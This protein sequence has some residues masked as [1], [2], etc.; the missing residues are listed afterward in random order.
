ME[1]MMKRKGLINW[2]LAA[3]LTAGCAML[4]AN[5]IVPSHA[6]QIAAS[7]EYD[8]VARPEGLSSDFHLRENASL[9]F[10][11]IKAIDGF[12]VDASLWQ[13]NGKQPVDTTLIIMIH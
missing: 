11:A 5:A 7:I 2:G 3:S 1:G 12:P 9:K 6:A 4:G 8:F 13:P 10:L